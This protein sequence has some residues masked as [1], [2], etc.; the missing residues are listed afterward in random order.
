MGPV[1]SGWASLPERALSGGEKPALGL[2]QERP[3]TVPF[4]TPGGRQMEKIPDPFRGSFVDG[5]PRDPALAC[6]KKH[7]MDPKLVAKV[8]T[9]IL[10]E[11]GETRYAITVTLK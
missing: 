3:K 4:G 8:L 10:A 5:Y 9:E 7:P 1:S 6:Y 2:R 11:R